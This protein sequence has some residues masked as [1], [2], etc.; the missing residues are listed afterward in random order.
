MAT[1]CPRKRRLPP[2]AV[3][4]FA[5]AG[6]RLGLAAITRAS[7]SSISAAARARTCFPRHARPGPEASANQ[8]QGRPARLSTTSPDLEATM[9]GR[10]TP[11]TVDELPAADQEVVR[12]ALLASVY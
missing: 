2:E 1:R 12:H 7:G 5:A 8:L 4:S 10:G 11:K 3:E 6:Y 9:A